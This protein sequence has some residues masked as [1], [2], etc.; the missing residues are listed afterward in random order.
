MAVDGMLITLTS[1]VQQVLGWPA[2]QF[3]LVAAMMTVTAAA[4][5]LLSQRIVTRLG[6]R[7]VGAAG[8]AL[9][10]CGCLLTRIPAGSPMSLLPAALLLFG[11]GMGA[12]TVCAQITA[13][14]GVTENDSGLAPAPSSPSAPPSALTAICTSIAA[15]RASAIGGPAPLALTA[16][17][18]AEFEAAGVFAALAFITAL[19]L[20]GKRSGRPRTAPANADKNV[21]TRAPSTSP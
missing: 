11:A 21:S 13:L 18:H 19:M 15:A 1:F 12:A 7:R 4:S 6:L 3:A 5:A 2:M 20:L 9:L 17:Q 14:A 10:G 8:T 16:G